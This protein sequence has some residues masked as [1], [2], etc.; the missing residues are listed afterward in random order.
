MDTFL[1]FRDDIRSNAKTDFKT[2]L[3]ICD[4]VRDYDLVELNIRV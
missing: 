4:R 2:L 1:R 3:D